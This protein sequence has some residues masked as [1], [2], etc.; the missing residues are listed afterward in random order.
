M[1]YDQWDTDEAYNWATNDFALYDTLQDCKESRVDFDKTLCNWLRENKDRT[2]NVDC[3]LVDFD[4][5]YTDF[6]SD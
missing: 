2:N 3:E 1:P 4:E 5:V 6:C